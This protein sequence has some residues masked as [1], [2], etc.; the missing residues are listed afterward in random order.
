LLG[1]LLTKQ[2]KTPTMPKLTLAELPVLHPFTVHCQIVHVTRGRLR[3]RIPLLSDD[4]GYA[5]SLLALV[6]LLELITEVRVN[7]AA[8]SLVVHYAGELSAVQVL[9]RLMPTIQQAASIPVT[10]SEVSNSSLRGMGWMLLATGC[11]AGMQAS[12][13]F[14]SGAIHPFQIAFLSHLIGIGILV[15]WV[16]KSSVLQTDQ[17]P[18]HLLRAVIDT[19]ATLLLFTGLSLTPLAQANVIGFTAP[20]FAILGAVAF[21]GERMQ[22]HTWIALTL[23]VLGML[24]ILRPGAEAV[25]LG[26][27][28]M[29][30]GSATLGAV[31]LLIKA[32]SRTDSNLTINVY[33]VLLL[34]PLLFVPSLL[35]WQTPT[36]LDLF[37]LTVVAALMVGGHMAMTQALTEAEMITVL[38]VEFAQLLW[39]SGL[40]YILFSETLDFWTLVGGILIFSGS[41]YAGYFEN[42]QA[43][44]L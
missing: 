25:G 35:V 43:V 12:I 5:D 2:D 7:P 26:A 6:R 11:F 20:L 42:G 17:L 30:T 23:G 27:L 19:G 36:I 44:E 41:T 16:A 18:L 38:P 28:L 31:M 4:A 29:L 22:P 39:A 21:L 33:T 14:V 40:G 37:W 8:Q 32:L 1:Q 34:T 9:D 24:V 15:P 10:Q 13:R 3:V